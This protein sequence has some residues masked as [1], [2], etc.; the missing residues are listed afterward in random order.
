MQ[1]LCDFAIANNTVS[2]SVALHLHDSSASRV[3]RCNE[4]QMPIILEYKWRRKKKTK[5]RRVLGQALSPNY[6]PSRFYTFIPMAWIYIY[7]YPWRKEEALVIKWRAVSSPACLAH[8]GIYRFIRRGDN[9]ARLGTSPARSRL[10]FLLGTKRPVSHSR[11][12][13]TRF[14]ELAAGREGECYGK[15]EARRDAS[16]KARLAPVINYQPV[17]APVVFFNFS[18]RFSNLFHPTP[19]ISFSI[20]RFI[21]LHTRRFEINISACIC[22][23]SLCKKQ[24][25]V[26]NRSS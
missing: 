25:Y 17:H 24:K 20:A 15:K 3:K 19:T 5:N 9:A 16:V 7:P 11:T 2:R 23:C 21:I 26:F 4:S 6:A 1:H 8:R 12:A 22:I 14:V 18:P 13:A 10:E